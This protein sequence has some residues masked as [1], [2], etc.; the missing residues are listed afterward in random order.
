MGVVSAIVFFLRALIGERAAIAAENLALRQ[1]LGVRGRSVK[2]PRLRQCNR[3]LWVWLA[4]LWA[5]WRSSLLSQMTKAKPSTHLVAS[6]IGFE[7]T[8]R[9]D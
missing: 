9:R 3:I 2:R 5:D 1:Q 7:M 4:R 6:H 8:K